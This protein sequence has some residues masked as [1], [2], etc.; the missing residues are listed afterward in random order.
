MGSDVIAVY[1]IAFRVSLTYTVS[2]CLVRGSGTVVRSPDR[3]GAV[4]DKPPKPYDWSQEES[5][6]PED[7]QSC[8]LLLFAGIA[9]GVA[10][11]LLYT[12]R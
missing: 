12:L 7:W 3:L 5:P 11:V 9:I 1:C 4:P 10:M 6:T 2:D 8:L